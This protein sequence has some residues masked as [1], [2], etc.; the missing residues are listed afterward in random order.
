MSSS[1]KKS[2]DRPRNENEGRLSYWDDDYRQGD[3][4]YGPGVGEREPLG[5]E[6]EIGTSRAAHRAGDA[7]V[8]MGNSRDVEAIAL[9]EADAFLDKLGEELFGNSSGMTLNQSPPSLMEVDSRAALVVQYSFGSDSAMQNIPGDVESP[10]PNEHGGQRQI[11]PPIEPGKTPRSLE[12]NSQYSSEVL[13]LFQNH[14]NVRRNKPMRRTALE[15]W[16]EMDGKDGKNTWVRFPRDSSQADT[17]KLQGR[18]T[19]TL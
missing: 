10:S 4:E 16:D 11:S 19:W 3:A 6:G 9:A 18:I 17:N 12:K 7:D 15:I 8:S 13:K 5:S 2:K 14:E 1:R